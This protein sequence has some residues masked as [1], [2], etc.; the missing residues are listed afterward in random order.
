M[1]EIKSP[2]LFVEIKNILEEARANT[3]RSVNTHI[4]DAYW[5]DNSKSTRWQQDC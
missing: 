1:L 2:E 5:Q 4:I 3:Y